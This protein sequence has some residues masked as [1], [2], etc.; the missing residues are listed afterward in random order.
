[1]SPAE[2]KNTK[3]AIFIDIGDAT[4]CVHVT[5]YGLKHTSRFT[6]GLHLHSGF[7]IQCIKK[8]T[9]FL[10]SEDSEFTAN[11]GDIVIIPQ[12]VYHQNSVLSE[13]FC[14]FTC[15]FTIL[16]NSAFS[17]SQEYLMYN[18]VLSR[19][20]KM[21]VLPEGKARS[22]L[23]MLENTENLNST[24]IF[25][26]NRSVL[27]IFLIDVLSEISSRFSSVQAPN[28]FVKIKGNTHLSEKQKF[29]ITNCLAENF[30]KDTTALEIERGLGMSKRN[31]ARIVYNLFGK[32]VSELVLEHRMG[33]ASAWIKNSDE[34]L[35]E[36]AERVGYKTYVAFFTAFKKYYGESP[37]KYRE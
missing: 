19:I 15:E 32:T 5:D 31:A 20:N 8:G 34:P 6:S 1:M 25:N 21:L 37:N 18:R 9:L 29:I 23:D 12:G 28:D 4:F 30:A 17:T 35:S 2:A 13:E 3:E 36:I 22:I 16:P 14:R 24:E 11:A 7:E 33:A 26:R 27:S 10:T